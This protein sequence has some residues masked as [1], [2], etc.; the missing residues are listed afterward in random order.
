MQDVLVLQTCRT[1]VC[2]FQRHRS[3]P[4]TDEHHTVAFNSLVILQ[5]LALVYK[6]LLVS[7]CI[8]LARNLFL[9]LAHSCR[10]FNFSMEFFTARGWLDGH[11]DARHVLQ[12]V[13][14]VFASRGRDV[15]SC[16]LP[17]LRIRLCNKFACSRMYFF[18]LFPVPS[19]LSDV[20]EWFIRPAKYQREQGYR[21]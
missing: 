9:Q 8:A 2:F 7:R 6:P 20:G 3:T 12:M 14:P 16:P 15:E 5:N 4:H 1:G 19:S 10:G 17:S 21:V 13:S 11:L 18:L